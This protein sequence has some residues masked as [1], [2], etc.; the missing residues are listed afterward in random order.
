MEIDIYPWV[1]GRR[2]YER[3]GIY[4]IQTSDPRWVVKYAH[5]RAA[6]SKE[7]AFLERGSPYRNMIELPPDKSSR[8]GENWYAM[9]R[10]TGAAKGYEQEIAGRWRQLGCDVLNFLEDLHH[11]ERIVHL[12]IT[13][14]NILYDREASRFV[15]SDYELMSSV[16]TDPALLDDDDDHLW[17]YIGAGAELSKPI[18]SWRMDL[19]M[20]GYCLEELTR[21]SRWVSFDKQCQRRRQDNTMS[22]NDYDIIQLRNS[23]MAGCH[24]TVRTYLDI[25]NDLVP[26]EAADPPPAAVY[27]EL[28][29]CLDIQRSHTTFSDEGGVGSSEG[30][31]SSPS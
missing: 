5:N 8:F 1:A 4:I 25:L 12:D 11:G 2:L 17:Y 20:L 9:R 16:S 18:H 22:M 26:W 6:I 19:T 15:V 30:V 31:D 14:R 28:R 23:Q 3:D 10:Y 13:L 24:P 29:S 21:G 27:N 7:I